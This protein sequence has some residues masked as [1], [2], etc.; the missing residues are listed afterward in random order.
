MLNCLAIVY[1]ELGNYEESLRICDENLKINGEKQEILL[2]KIQAIF[3]NLCSNSAE[4]ENA[5]NLLKKLT[6]NKLI[7]ELDIRIREKLY[8]KQKIEK[9]VIES[10]IKSPIE[11]QVLFENHDEYINPKNILYKYFLE[12]TH[13][14]E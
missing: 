3:Y 11:K 12:I 6:K 9:K 14:A 8:E 4:L 2:N 13:I 1:L 5:Y 10:V 7:S